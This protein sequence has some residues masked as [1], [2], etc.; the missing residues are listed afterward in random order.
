MIERSS[1][2]QYTWGGS[3]DAWHLVKSQALSVIQEL[4]PP[5]TSEQLHTHARS[6]QFFYVLSG[7]ATFE[8]GDARE[9]IRSHQGLEIPPGI[10][11][12]ISNVSGEN[13]EF[14]VISC[15]PA[16]GDREPVPATNE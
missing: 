11:H 12:R 3:C 14:L 1:A 13:L 9:V 4:M 2:E 10:P 16:H 5:H 7:E 6:R 8:V 15:P